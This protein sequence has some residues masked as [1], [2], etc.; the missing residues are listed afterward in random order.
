MSKKLAFKASE[1]IDPQTM[2]GYG[3]DQNPVKDFAQRNNI[4]YEEGFPLVNPGCK[5][6]II[7][8]LDKSHDGKC[9]TVLGV[10]IEFEA[11]SGNVQIDGET[12]VTTLTVM[13]DEV[14]DLVNKL[15]QASRQLPTLGAKLNEDPQL[16]N[17]DEM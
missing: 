3:R 10:Q 11:G 7:D 2:P 4:A 15:V 1:P 16:C 5:P 8:M 6:V 9:G 17:Y 13:G 12:G 14:R